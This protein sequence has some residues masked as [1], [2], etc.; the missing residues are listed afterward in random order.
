MSVV[1]RASNALS[2]SGVRLRHIFSYPVPP[3][4]W[5]D[6]AAAM[7]GREL[8]SHRQ[9]P[10]KI[11]PHE[12]DEAVCLDVLVPE[13]TPIYAMADGEVAYVTGP[14]NEDAR[15]SGNFVRLRH[16]KRCGVFD[17]LYSHLM[18][19]PDVEIGKQV[20]QGEILGV[21]GHTGEGITIPHLHCEV[22]R[23]EGAERIRLL[24]YMAIMQGVQ[25]GAS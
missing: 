18:F 19:Y 13:G 1:E 22:H 8:T 17:T 9:N 21:V 11:V 10:W 6:A 4:D 5:W 15:N 16:H 3:D 2:G 12:S 14:P 23:I 25:C 20:L 7:K 24:P